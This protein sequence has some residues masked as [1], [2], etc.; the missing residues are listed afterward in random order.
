MNVCLW[1]DYI[2]YSIH[3]SETQVMFTCFVISRSHGLN[4]NC[5]RY[6]CCMYRWGRGTMV[7]GSGSL[8]CHAVSLIDRR[9]HY[10]ANCL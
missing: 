7:R 9:I 1:N 6:L 8:W 2:L 4:C 5:T 3:V 10:H